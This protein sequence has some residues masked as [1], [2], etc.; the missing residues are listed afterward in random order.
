MKEPRPQFHPARM[1]PGLDMKKY[2]SPA[3]HS[4]PVKYYEDGSGRDYYIKVNNGGLGSYANLNISTE[5]RSAF[6]K[7]LRTY[8]KIP[9]YLEKRAKI[10]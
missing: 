3:I 8:E 9:F 1:L 10:G 6:K 2:R 5:S 4:K 7:S